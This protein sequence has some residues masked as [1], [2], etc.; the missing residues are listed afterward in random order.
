MKE[1]VICKVVV[2]DFEV[3][4]EMLEG[5]YDGYDY[6][7]CVFYQWL[8][9]LNCVIFIVLYGDKVIGLRVIYIVD[10]GRIFISQG[11]CIYFRF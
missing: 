2:S 8:K 4:L 6:F 11:L 3:V 5:I 7:F 9:K 1:I 10:D